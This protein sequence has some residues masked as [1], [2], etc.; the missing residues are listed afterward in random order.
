MANRLTIKGQVTV[1]KE[2]RDFLHLKSGGSAIEF[3]IEEDGRVCIRK[4]P[5]SRHH[6]PS[7]RSLHIG[8]I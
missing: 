1:P 4:A 3:E 8:A 6:E 2:I 7:L 5:G